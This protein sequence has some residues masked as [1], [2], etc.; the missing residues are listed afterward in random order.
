MCR[1][2]SRFD[3]H[4]A[5]INN[6]V[7]LNNTRHFLAFLAANVVLTTY[8]SILTVHILYGEMKLSGL[9]EVILVEPATKREIPI[10]QSPRHIFEWT[11]VYFQ[12]PCLILMFL[13]VAGILTIAFLIYQLHGIARGKTTYETF[14]WKDL[15]R[16]RL[17]QQAKDPGG[18]RRKSQSLP[19]ESSGGS[20]GVL[21]WIKDAFTRRRRQPVELP[22][23]IYNRGVIENLMEVLRPDIALAGKNR[24]GKSSA[25]AA[26]KQKKR[27]R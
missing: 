17:K 16:S 9:L 21:N 1:C 18:R 7:G 4:C 11:L 8:G 2:V 26:A 3:H 20:G 14:R 13:V 22:G 25:A 19:A 27:S 6:C 5:W 23:N 24:I 15:H 10:T 12:T